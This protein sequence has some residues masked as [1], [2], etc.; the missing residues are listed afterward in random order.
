MASTKGKT[1][2]YAEYM[3]FRLVQLLL[4]YLPFAL[5][6]WLGERLGDLWRRLDRRHRETVRQ[7]AAERLELDAKALAAFTTDNFRHYG[8]LLAEFSRLDRLDSR[9]LAARTDFGT[10]REFIRHARQEGRGILAV[11]AHFGNW[12][13]CNSLAP[14]L[15]LEDGVAIA[16]PLDNQLLDGFTRRLRERNGLRILDKQGAIRGAL[17]ELKKGGVL[18][19]LLDQDAGPEGL[20]SPFLGKDASTFAI[21]VELARRAGASL[22]MVFALRD[23]NRAGHFVIRHWPEVFLPAQLSVEEQVAKINAALGLMVREDPGQWFWVHRRWKTGNGRTDW[24][25]R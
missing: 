9:A 12:E 13:W 22:V 19:V 3:A 10:T 1:S 25:S 16:R 21:P 2:I 14:F 6:L 7:Q 18:A 17:K 20:M 15:G 8:R 23:R 4:A 5:A 24:E 11:T